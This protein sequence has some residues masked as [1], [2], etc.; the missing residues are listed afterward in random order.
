MVE[1]QF[2]SLSGGPEDTRETEADRQNTALF[3]FMEAIVLR[4]ELFRAE[5]KSWK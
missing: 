1:K 5:S 4:A 2:V 3:W